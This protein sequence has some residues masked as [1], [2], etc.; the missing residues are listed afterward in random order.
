[1]ASGRWRDDGVTR[2]DTVACVDGSCRAGRADGGS[3]F[4]EQVLEKAEEREQR[5]GRGGERVELAPI[6][7]PH[8]TKD[9]VE[10]GGLVVHKAER[11]D[12]I[13]EALAGAQGYQGGGETDDIGE[14]LPRN[15]RLANR[16]I[17]KLFRHTVTVC[18]R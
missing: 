5:S 17:G 3:T 18:S 8:G 16:L 12:E 14:A 9:K 10:L 2:G 6:A 4:H 15:R 11:A 7:R 13:S 1:V